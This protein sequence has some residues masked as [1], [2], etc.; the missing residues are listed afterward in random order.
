MMLLRALWN[1]K[2]DMSLWV[3]WG[4]SEESH[5]LPETVW[6]RS[7]AAC[8]QEEPTKRL[9][10]Y[11]FQ[12]TYRALAARLDAMQIA[13]SWHSEGR[14]HA[15]SCMGV[16][17]AVNR[18]RHPPTQDKFRTTSSDIPTDMLR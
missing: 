15:V 3:R 2:I 5:R 17:R 6:E 11:P 9:R 7:S 8:L 10:A 18:G 4:W 12:H 1:L 14:R 13:T 16:G